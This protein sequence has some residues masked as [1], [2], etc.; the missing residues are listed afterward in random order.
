MATYDLTSSI[1]SSSSLAVGDILNCPYSGS[2]INITLPAGAYTLEAWGAQGGVYNST[3]GSA[4]MGGYSTGDIALSSDTTLYLYSGGQGQTATSTGTTSHS[5]G[6]NGG[7]VAYSRAGSGGG[8]SDI[9]VATDSLYARVLVAGGG[10]GAPYSGGKSAYSVVT[11]GAGGGTS[12]GIGGYGSSNQQ[13][14]ANIAGGGTQTSAG[15]NSANASNTVQATSASFGEGAGSS[16][17]SANYASGG[18]G[19]GWYGGGVGR[20]YYAGGGGGSGYVYTSSTASNYPSGCLLTSDYYLTNA[21]TI[22]GTNQFLSTSGTNETGHSGNGYVRI[23]IISLGTVTQYEITSSTSVQDYTLNPLGEQDVLEGATYNLYIYGDN[24]DKLILTDNG[25]DR[26]SSVVYTQED[27]TG[28]LGLLPSEYDSVNSSFASISDASNA[29][30]AYASQSYATITCNT[31]SGASTYFYLNFDTS[32]LPSNATIDSVTAMTKAYVSSTSNLNTYTVGVYS[33]TTLKGSTTALSSSST[34]ISLEPT[35]ISAS[36]LSDI[37][38]GFVVTRGTSQTTT[39]RS[40]YVYGGNITINYTVPNGNTYSLYTL[41]SVNSD[42]TI[43]ITK[44]P[45]N[46]LFLKS[47]G[48]WVSITHVYVK[49]NGSWVEQQLDYL[50]TQ[51]I[52]KLIQG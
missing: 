22:D 4:G 27:L 49:Q 2:S 11:A 50:S 46:E 51:S 36:D 33:G 17:Y 47:G 14:G 13:T 48:A 12:G 35:G 45:D 43:V 16:Y 30:T 25:I 40:L 42:H 52:Q 41:T 19:G 9:R 3:A 20:Y 5:G 32:A 37:K 34:E 38:I 18:G 28:A 26:T 39:S 29:Y 15:A 1:P 44:T 8:A 23:T 31:G 24:L 6:Y 21:S 10:G 7:G